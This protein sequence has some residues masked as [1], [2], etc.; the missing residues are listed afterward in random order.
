MPHLD[1][2]ASIGHKWPT[3]S[4]TSI[5]I[6]GAAPPILDSQDKVIVEGQMTCELVLCVGGGPALDLKWMPMGAWDDVSLSLVVV[7]YRAG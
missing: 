7:A 4:P 6:W 1:T 5:Q 2:K 3:S